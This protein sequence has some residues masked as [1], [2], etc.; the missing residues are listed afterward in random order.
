MF[1][2]VNNRHLLKR[3][4]KTLEFD[5]FSFRMTPCLSQ[6]QSRSK[7]A[8]MPFT[9]FSVS[10]LPFPI[11]S[12]ISIILPVFFFRF[13]TLLIYALSLSYKIPNFAAS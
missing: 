1:I 11:S 9:A 6:N 13:Y 10:S 7:A 8:K 12:L 5:V 2:L 3:Q 4:N